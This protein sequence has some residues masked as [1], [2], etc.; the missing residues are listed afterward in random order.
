MSIPTPETNDALKDKLKF[1]IQE[2]E[3]TVGELIVPR[4]VTQVEPNIEIIDPR[5]VIFFF[6]AL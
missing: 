3:F 6:S 4:E 1:Q 5:A 2:G